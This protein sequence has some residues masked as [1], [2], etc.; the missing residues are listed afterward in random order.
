VTVTVIIVSVVTG[1]LLLG[2]CLFGL[3]Y[4]CYKWCKGRK[5][6]QAFQVQ[7]EEDLEDVGHSY[8]KNSL[9]I[10]ELVE[11]YKRGELN[12]ED[13]SAKRP[14]IEEE[15]GLQEREQEGP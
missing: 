14:T 12:L 9:L 2:L 10:D 8:N 13:L 15:E 5:T 11:Q 6:G 4:F 7:A 1:T 3:I